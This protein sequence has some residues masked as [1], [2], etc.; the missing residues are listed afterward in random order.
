MP[1]VNK[2]LENSRPEWLK[3]EPKFAPEIMGLRAQLRRLKLHTVCESARCPNL[4]ECFKKKT[5]TLMILGNICTRN[6]SFCAVKKGI[7]LPPDPKEPE[8]I[9]ELAKQLELKHIVITS[10]TRDDLSDQGA[11][12]FYLSVKAVKK[13]LPNSTVEVLTSD[14]GGNLDLVARVLEAMPEIYNHNVETVPRLYPLVR[15]KA[16][17]SRSLGIINFVKANAK[18]VIT[19]SGLMLGL[20]EEKKEV[21]RVMRDLVNVGCEVLTLGQYLSPSKSHWQVQRYYLPE[22]FDQLKEIGLK[23]GFKEVFSG[24]LVRSSFCAEEIYIKFK[25]GE[26]NG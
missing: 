7:P 6:C 21:A 5:T 25:E 16:D 23:I 11:E 13:A 10:V 22:E 26:E 18:K 17:Y 15:P 3:A 20:G 1:M 14:F 2:N 9:A 24:P 4:G 8:H 12:Q 19:K